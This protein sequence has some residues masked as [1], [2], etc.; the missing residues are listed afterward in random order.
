MRKNIF[1]LSFIILFLQNTALV[2]AELANTPWPYAY[3]D[4]KQTSRTTAIGPQSP[5]IRWML[6]IANRYGETNKKGATI[7][8]DGQTIFFGTGF[9]GIYAVNKFTGAV[10]WQRVPEAGVGPSPCAPFNDKNNEKWIG[11]PPTIGADGTL[12]APSEYGYALTLDPNN[13]AFKTPDDPG[14]KY[15]LYSCKTEHAAAMDNDSIYFGSWDGNFYAYKITGSHN[16]PADDPKNQ[17]ASRLKWKYQFQPINSNGTQHWSNWFYTYGSPSIG[18]DGTVY[19]AWKGVWA[20]DPRETLPPG[21]NR[22]KWYR[23]VPDNVVNGQPFFGPAIGPDGTLYTTHD[24]SLFAIS[25]DGVHKWTVATAGNVRGRQPGIGP[26]GTVYFGS[27]DGYLYAVNPDGTTKWKFSVGCGSTF[28]STLID[29]AGTIYHNT[30]CDTG[31]TRLYAVNPNGTEKWRINTGK[32]LSGRQDTVLS[33]DSD[34]T[35]YGTAGSSYVMA[36]EQNGPTPTPEATPTITPTP[37]MKTRKPG[38]ATGDGI[39]NVQDYNILVT[40]FNQTGANLT[41]DFNNSGKVDVQD[42]NILVSNFGA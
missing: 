41:A 32:A 38:D 20:F 8:I 37:T 9:N 27:N 42:Y 10:K 39:I 24:R 40:Q 26:D 35:I 5:R 7:G 30:N 3:K 1:V 19:L 17:S 6:E 29:G 33:M 12:Y 4:K 13:G 16:G 18:D 14:L 28:G 36:V 21:T 34:G 2:H 23:K 15:K 22:L 31:K 11:M 25:R